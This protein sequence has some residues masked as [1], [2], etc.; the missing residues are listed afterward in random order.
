MS[1]GTETAGRGGGLK[2]SNDVTF[3]R[4]RTGHSINSR[5]PFKGNQPPHRLELCNIQ[6]IRCTYITYVLNAS[7]INRKKFL[8]IQK[9]FQLLKFFSRSN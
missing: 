5:I 9:I 7:D 2:F 8:K 4:I 3:I 6:L 1:L